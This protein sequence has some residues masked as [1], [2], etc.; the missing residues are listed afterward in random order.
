MIVLNLLLKYCLLMKR[1]FVVTHTVL[2]TE[3][4][5]LLGSWITNTNCYIHKKKKLILYFSKNIT[6]LY[7][8]LLSKDQVFSVFFKVVNRWV[9]R[10]CFFMNDM[11]NFT[12]CVQTI[13]AFLEIIHKLKT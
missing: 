2:Q 1:Q 11:N 12:A 6:C 9:T 7:V 3:I 4:P 13:H 10:N 8:S 5:A